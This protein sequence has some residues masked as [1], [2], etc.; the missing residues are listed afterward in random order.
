VRRSLWSLICELQQLRGKPQGLLLPFEMNIHGVVARNGSDNCRSGDRRSGLA[1][2]HTDKTSDTSA[3]GFR[4][5]ADP[6]LIG[7]LL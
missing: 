6:N 1:I 5:G 4:G 2:N 7:Y 3:L